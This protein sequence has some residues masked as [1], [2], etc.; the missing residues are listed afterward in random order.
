MT[1]FFENLCSK[2]NSFLFFKLSLQTDQSRKWEVEHFTQPRNIS[3]V[4]SSEE[5]KKI[6]DIYVFSKEK[7]SANGKEAKEN[8]LKKN[9]Y[10]I[11]MN[12]KIQE[13]DYIGRC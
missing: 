9:I 8:L 5:R 7:R 6:L 3:I 12:I 13:I 1:R 11:K 2:K 4:R 10:P